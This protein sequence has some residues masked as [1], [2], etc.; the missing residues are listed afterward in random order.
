MDTVIS[1][2]SRAQAWVSGSHPNGSS[3]STTSSSI[4]YQPHGSPQPQTFRGSVLHSKRRRS[5]TP[6]RQTIGLAS[7]RRAPKTSGADRRLSWWLGIDFPV[8][9]P[10]ASFASCA[11]SA[12][13]AC[14]HL[15]DLGGRGLRLL[16]DNQ[17]CQLS[18]RSIGRYLFVQGLLKK[19][20]SPAETHRFSP[21]A[22]RAVTG[23]LIVLD[24][25]RRR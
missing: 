4:K 19:R 24:R 3:S 15:L 12:R 17:L 14:R 18:Q 16:I 6:Q 9:T 5:Q 20:P 7:H 1:F 10:L 25:L 22:E 11:F 23:N 21:G 8:A 2:S 13:P